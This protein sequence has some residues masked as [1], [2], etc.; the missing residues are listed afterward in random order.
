MVE[1]FPVTRVAP[2]TAAVTVRPGPPIVIDVRLTAV[3]FPN[4][5]KLPP[6]AGLTPCPPAGPPPPPAPPPPTGPRPRR[7][8]APRPPESPGPSE[9]RPLGPW[10]PARAAP[11]PVARGGE[12]WSTAA[13]AI[14]P[15]AAAAATMIPART[16][17]RIRRSRGAVPG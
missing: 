10:A 8:G 14:P 6:L 4:Q 11:E 7:G 1:T 16:A 12:R 13:A 9:T 17:G 2:V 3:N 5:N 15:P